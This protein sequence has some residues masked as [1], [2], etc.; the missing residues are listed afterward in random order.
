MQNE[1]G[2]QCEVCID[3]VAGALAAEQA[4]ADRVELCSDLVEGG[5]TPS[6]GL[7]QAVVRATRLPV[8]V[9]IRPRG[10]DFCFEQSEVEIMLADIRIARD[11][12]VAGVV[13]GALTTDG[14]IDL[15]TCQ[16]LCEQADGLG[17]TFHRAFDWVA[18]PLQSLDE[19]MGLPRVDRLLTSGQQA[20]AV[21]GIPLLRELVARAQDRLSVMP[22]SGVN[23]GNA[24]VLLS[25]TK[26][27]ELHFSAGDLVESEVTFRR[28]NV[29]MSAERT[30]GDAFRR[31]T[32]ADKAQ[33]IV[34]AVR[35]WK[36]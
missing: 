24:G 16:V 27:R 15:P 14:K 26:C 33:A 34:A 20:I 32:S 23:A 17:V 31:I 1:S 28:Q 11:C 12:G 35:A 7:I 30:P 5:I 18:D 22:G 36:P 13:I 6:A 19:I 3:S 25:E 2:I 8:M 29:P 4:G 21:D 10:G 9:M